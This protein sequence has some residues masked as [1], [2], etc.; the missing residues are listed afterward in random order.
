MPEFKCA[1]GKTYS[2]EDFFQQHEEKCDVVKKTKEEALAAPTP[3]P[4]PAAK[5][6]RPSTPQP[7]ELDAKAIAPTSFKALDAGEHFIVFSSYQFASV[8]LEQTTKSVPS[9]LVAVQQ[10]TNRNM[11]LFFKKR[12]PAAPLPKKGG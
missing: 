3:P 1:C 11:M 9:D 12:D 5:P 4:T 7:V 10:L 8:V 6:S 2:R